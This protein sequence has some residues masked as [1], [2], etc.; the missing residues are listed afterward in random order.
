MKNEFDFYKNDKTWFIDLPSYPGDV[1]DL[2]MVLGADDMLEQLSKGQHRVT[3]TI[4]D[5]AF[6]DADG[7]LNIDHNLSLIEESLRST[8]T[9]IGGGFY[10]FDD[11]GKYKSVWLCDVTKYVFANDIMPENIW[12]KVVD[13]NE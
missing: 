4:S 1:A 3:L 10:I 8:A 5:S 11:G 9:E 2:A 12:F 6:D 7:V 13:M